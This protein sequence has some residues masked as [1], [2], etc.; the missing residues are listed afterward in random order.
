MSNLI[1]PP[2]HHRPPGRNAPVFPTL[3]QSEKVR[4][5]L[6]Q[7]A[8]QVAE[9]DQRAMRDLMPV[10]R[11]ARRELIAG[12][13]RWLRVMPEGGSRFTAQQKRAALL[14]IERAM[15]ELAKAEPALRKILFESIEKSGQLASRHLVFEVSRMS[16]VFGDLVIPQIDTALV[17]KQGEKLLVK[18]FRT[19]AQRYRKRVLEDIK[20][21]FGIGL[22]KGET[23]DQLTRRLRRL[24]GPR[25]QVP[26]RGGVPDAAIVS[27][28]IA[29]GLFRRYRHWAERLVR[30]EMIHAYNTQHD[31]AIG[32]LNA[33]RVEIGQEPLQKRWDASLDRRLC[34]ICSDLD[35]RVVPH[36]KPFEPGLDYPPAHPNCRC[37]VTAWD[38]EWGD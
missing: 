23:F 1:I 21:Q 37:I 15:V 3:T 9:L 32:V 5:M 4:R 38:P 12:L 7:M 6:E 16:A 24:G 20:H 2:D 17:L 22:A 11:D 36:G 13:R 14:S 19:S 28:Q 34:P 30:T 10:L 8:A 31:E 35:G 18:R 26:I 33:D 27:E 29:G 25:G